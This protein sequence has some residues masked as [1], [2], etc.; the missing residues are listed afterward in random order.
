MIIPAIDFQA[1][2]VVQLV[3]GE[4][5][6]LERDL[7]EMLDAFAG[8]PWLQVIDLDAAKGEGANGAL[9]RRC[10]RAGFRVRVGGGIRSRARAE[11]VLSWG[12]ERLILGSAAFRADGV[13]TAFLGALAPLGQERL[14]VAVDS[15]NDHVAVAGWRQLLALTPAEAIRMAEPQCGGFLYTHIDGEG[16]MQGTSLPAVRRLRAATRLPIS[17]AGG[18]ASMAEITALEALGCDAVLGMALYTEKLALAGLR[19]HAAATGR[20]ALTEKDKP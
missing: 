15:R 13:N 5:L 19:A 16:L 14:I 6:A 12:A 4:R 11:E 3:Q 2:R 7:E 8:F 1:G 9:V 17:V 10:C 20:A 18:I